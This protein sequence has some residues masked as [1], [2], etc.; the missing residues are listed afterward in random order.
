MKRNPLSYLH[1]SKPHLNFPDEKKNIEKHFTIATKK[2]EEFLA[3]G[4]VQKVKPQVYI[5]RQIKDGRIYQGIISGVHADDYAEERIKKHELTRTDKEDEMVGQMRITHTIS[6]AVLV[7]YH[8]TDEIEELT[9]KETQEKPYFDFVQRGVRHTIWITKNEDLI[10]KALGHLDDVYIADGHHRSASLVRYAR[11]QKENNPRHTGN[12]PYNFL[13]TYFVPSNL[14]YVYE[15]NRLVQDINSTPFKIMKHI[16]DNFEVEKKKK[17]AYQPKKKHNFGMYYHD[18]WYKLK[19]KTNIVNDA[20]PLKC[21]DVQILEDYLLKPVLNIADSK[22]DDRLSFVDGTKG[23]GFLQDRVDKGKA[24]IAFTLFPTE[25][26][27]VMAVADIHATMPPKSTWIEPK[28]RT[29][30]IV[31]DLS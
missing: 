8:Q 10:C 14:L 13:Q 20:D 1:V 3:E 30:F 9:K 28:M 21:L 11:E 19:A 17:E 27:Q 12:E 31:Q 2:L 4:I 23:L 24:D 22:T 15:Y 29:G 6:T 18:T 7:T 26:E 16:C 5:Y 25:I